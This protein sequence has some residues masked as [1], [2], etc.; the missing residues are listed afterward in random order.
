MEQ[1]GSQTIEAAREKLEAERDRLLRLRDGVSD[2][3]S[4]DDSGR[5][6]SDELS[7]VDQHPADVG[8]EVF[9]RQKDDSIVQQFDSEL[10]EIEAALGRVEEGSYGTCETCG[11]PIG[12]ERLDAI[13][14]ARYCVDDQASAEREQV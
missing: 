12:R 13:P 8:S 7:V 2:E 6:E 10:V 1:R 4:A 3:D 11:R 14:Q 9:E 5:A